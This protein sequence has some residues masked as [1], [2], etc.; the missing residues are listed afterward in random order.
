MGKFFSGRLRWLLTHVTVLFLLSALCQGFDF[1]PLPGPEEFFEMLSGMGDFFRPSQSFLTFR[2]WQPEF[3]VSKSKLGDVE[4]QEAYFGSEIMSSYF[5]GKD[6]SGMLVHTTNRRLHILMHNVSGTGSQTLDWVELG[7]RLSEL[8]IVQP[9]QANSSSIK[10]RSPIPLD[11]LAVFQNPYFSEMFVIKEAQSNALMVT[12]D[13]GQTFK[14]LTAITKRPQVVSKSATKQ[15]DPDVVE[16]KFNPLFK[17]WLLVALKWQPSQSG[18][19]LYMSKDYADW[20]EISQSV[21]AF[22][23]VANYANLRSGTAQDG[24]V[25]LRRNIKGAKNNNQAIRYSRVHKNVNLL[26]LITD[27][28][29]R[30]T[31]LV[32]FC[33]KYYLT[34]HFLYASQIM[35]TWDDPRMLVKVGQIAKD[36]VMKEA[37]MPQRSNPRMISFFE[38]DGSVVFA[39]FESDDMVQKGLE[40]VT[41]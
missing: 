31:T 22:D 38:F 21:V 12:T 3:D 17:D 28:G 30:K 13:C 29:R 11:I 10:V 36:I 41:S 35:G 16:I 8:N 37:K 40:S 6:H 24:I 20:Q 1:L 25:V 26:E 27:G 34:D 2:E 23:W 33:F 4:T 5:C 9:G 15:G 14:L 39:N 32:E 19:R 18:S 7:A